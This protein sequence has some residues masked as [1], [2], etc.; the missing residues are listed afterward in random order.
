MKRR[1]PPEK[2]NHWA[3]VFVL[4]CVLQW[5]NGKRSAFPLRRVFILTSASFAQFTRIPTFHAFE[6]N[7]PH[8]NRRS[9]GRCSFSPASRRNDLPNSTPRDLIAIACFGSTTG[10]LPFVL[11]L[12]TTGSKASILIF[13]DRQARVAMPARVRATALACGCEF[14]EVGDLERFHRNEKMIARFFY[15]HDFLRVNHRKYK[16]VCLMD[17]ADIVFQCD[18]FRRSFREN[19]LR[20]TEENVNGSEWQQKTASIIVGQKIAANALSNVRNLNVGIVTGNTKSLLI[21][22]SEFR[23]FFLNFS[24]DKINAI[25]QS[26]IPDQVI[27]NLIIRLRNIPY[28]PYESGGLFTSLWRLFNRPEISWRLGEWRKH[29]GSD[30]ACAVHMYDRSE[31]FT[32]SVLQRCAPFIERSDIRFDNVRFD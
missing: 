14:V 30:F 32:G 9:C 12:R 15:W 10:L 24:E 28:I 17:S 31:S 5:V 22:L 19:F 23:W 27:I 8:L 4:F 6:S 1:P 3:Y 26:Y 25:I 13:I 11:T 18:P 7:I 16:R 29:N 20:V 21:L 2:F